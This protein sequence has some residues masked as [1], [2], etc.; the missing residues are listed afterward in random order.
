VVNEARNSRKLSVGLPEAFVSHWWNVGL[1]YLLT[2]LGAN[3]IKSG[4]TTMAKF[5]RGIELALAEF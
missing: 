4:K 2:A 5:N 1:E 3:I